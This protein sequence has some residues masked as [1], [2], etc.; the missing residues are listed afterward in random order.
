MAFGKDQGRVGNMNLRQQ[1]RRGSK[2]APRGEGGGG[3]GGA[4]YRNKYQPPTSGP[5]DIIRLIPGQY[6]TPRVDVEVKD[7]VYDENG[8][9]VTDLFTYWKYISYYHA[10]K[11]RSCVGSEGP[12]G[13][14]KGKGQPCVAADWFW[15]E[16]RQRTKNHADKP[17]SMRRSDMFAFTVLVQAPF[18][19]VPDTDRNTGQ[20]RINEATKEP[21][22]EWK[23]GAKRGND[24]FAAA[25]FERKEGH[26]QHWSLGRAHWEVLTKYADGLAHHC[27]S[28]NTQNSIEEVA[29]LCQGCGEAIVEFATTSFSDED[30]E[31]LRNEEVLCKQ[32]GFTGYLED[33]IRCTNCSHG[34]QATLFDFDLEVQ[35]VETAGRDGGNQTA[36]QILRAIGPRPIDPIYGED[37]RKALDL[38]KIFAPTPIKKQIELFGEPPTDDDAGGG[39]QRQPSNKGV[40]P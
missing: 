5:A 18:Y 30:L 3:G 24:E 36:L 19:K 15:W 31:R 7:F 21:F 40:Q 4:Y 39:V 12:L 11:Q 13:E 25:G 17:K 10:T 20:V 38:P 6:P 34:E 22:F 1:M 29:L 2:R 23:K 16:W 27:R 33:M 28:C 35:R 32:C 9:I 14:F 26:L 8:Q 37:L